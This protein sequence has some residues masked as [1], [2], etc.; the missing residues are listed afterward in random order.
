MIGLEAAVLEI[1]RLFGGEFEPYDPHDA[2][3]TLLV[4]ILILC[5]Y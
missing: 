5:Y 3:L 4:V 1:Q 2:S